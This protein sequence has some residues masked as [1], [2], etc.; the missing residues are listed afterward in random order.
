MS[1][2]TGI[3]GFQDGAISYTLK[4]DGTASFGKKGNGQI[5]VSGSESY[6][7]SAGYL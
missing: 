3:Y 7:A 1:T 2:L 4:E 6:I 5:I